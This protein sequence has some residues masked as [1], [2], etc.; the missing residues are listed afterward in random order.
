MKS[1]VRLGSGSG[2]WGDTLRPEALARAE[3]VRETLLERFER[4]VLRLALDTE[5]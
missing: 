4:I 1:V 3:K 2:F 5:D